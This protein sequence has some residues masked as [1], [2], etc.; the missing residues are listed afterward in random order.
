MA[1]LYNE[2]TGLS[3]ASKAGASGG[4]K[5]S[6]LITNGNPDP[7]STKTAAQPYDRAS[8][9]QAGINTLYDTALEAQ[10]QGLLDAYNSNTQAQT[11]LG[12]QMQNIYGAAGYDLGVQNARNAANLNQF[13]DVRGVN[14]GMG[15]QQSL[16]LGNAMANSA[17]LMDVA[18]QSA[19]QENERQ[20][21]MLT[22]SYNNQ[23]QAA[24]A[25]ND[26]KRAAA[27]LDDYK[28]QNAWQE[29][30]AQILASFGNFEPY[31]ELYGTE[32][33]TGMEQIWNAQNPDVAYRLGRI[34]ANTYKNITGKWPRG[35]TPP[36][37]GGGG[38]YG[39]AG[40]TGSKKEM[41]L[42]GKVGFA[43]KQ[44]ASL[45]GVNNASYTSRTPKGGTTVNSKGFS[46]KSGSF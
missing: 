33:A 21:Q 27:L 15:S 20:K 22:T 31:S 25:D 34:S 18:R 14:R 36:S 40:T 10:R 38:Y 30:Q 41:Q 8:E 46:G 44:T 45:Y 6:K 16:S 43:P 1:L 5:Q 3:T 2:N 37:T 4:E 32:A 42:A 13:A 17:G 19:L 11:Q 35:Y 9:S 24:I 23:V 12:Q 28:N 26:Y 39:G 29:Q 7:T